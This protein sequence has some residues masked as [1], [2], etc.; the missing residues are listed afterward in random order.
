MDRCRSAGDA[1]TTR[2]SPQP[3]D[4][5]PTI[6]PFPAKKPSPRIIGSSGAIVS[7]ELGEM[8]SPD[9]GV[10]KAW[11]KEGSQP[12][13]FSFDQDPRQGEFCLVGLP[14]VREDIHECH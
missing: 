11:G 14:A 2:S 1:P 10:R 6:P 3:T 7:S 5:L 8:P 12:I 13:H 9:L 4:L